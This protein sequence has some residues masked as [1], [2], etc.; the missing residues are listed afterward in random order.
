MAR[1]TSTVC[2]RPGCWQLQPCAVH[3]GRHTGWSPGRDRSAQ[4]RFRIAVLKRDDYT[5]VDCGH[6]DPTGRSLRAAHLRPLHEGGGYDLSEGVTR[7]QKC[8]RATDPHAR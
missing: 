2:S 1:R 3:G 8:D 4:R 5:C 7:C 6:H